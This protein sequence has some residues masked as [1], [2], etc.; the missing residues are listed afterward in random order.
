MITNNDEVKVKLMDRDILLLKIISKSGS[1]TF[2]FLQENLK[3]N[4]PRLDKLVKAGYIVE[5]N[6]PT[7]GGKRGKF[8]VNRYSYSLGPNGVEHCKI[9]RYITAHGGHNGHDHA[10]ITCSHVY[11]LLENEKIP[12]ENIKNEKELEVMYSQEIVKA[13]RSRLKY[14]VC[15]LAV[16]LETGNVTIYEI[17]TA[18]YRKEHR[19]KHK[20]FAFKIAKVSKENY[21]VIKG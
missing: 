1:A 20:N 18:N 10:H 19:E 6:D 2:K 5:N 8:I 16:I 11:D 4:K 17:E 14:S 9:N 15:D 12:I 7:K 13:N 3:Y 21:K